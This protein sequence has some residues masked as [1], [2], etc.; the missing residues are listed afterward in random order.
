VIGV[1]KAY[2][3]RVGAGP[4]PTEEKGPLGE[5]LRGTGA[6]PW[7]EF[8]TTTGR[9]RR[10]GWLDLV[11]LKYSAQINGFT[12]LALVK[13][14][15]FSGFEE[16]KVAVA[17]RHGGELL[18]EFPTTTEILSECKPV[19]ETL[20]G[21]SEGLRGCRSWEDLPKNAW[22]YVRF[23]EEHLEVPVSLISVGRTSEET[24]WLK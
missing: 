21:W 6:N 22:R 10:C 15:V 18:E 19:Y 7:D 14:D 4:F 8:G 20:P 17:Y 23:I 24:I 13:L 11:A 1:L 9:P 12:E 2:T 5:R 3:T 16:L